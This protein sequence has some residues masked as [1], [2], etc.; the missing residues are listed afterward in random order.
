VRPWLGARGEG[1]DSIKAAALGLDRPRGVLIS[2]VYA[3]GPA[4]KAGLREGDVVLSI[5]GREVFDDKGMKFIAATKA[6]G[7]AV[8]V[9]LLRN[10]AQRTLRATLAAPPG[11]AK[12]ELMVVAGRN[13]FTGAQVAQLSPALAEQLGLDPFNARDGMLVYSVPPRTI[14]RNVGFQ[15]GDIIREIN[16]APIRTPKDLETAI[17][18]I[19]GG[20]DGIWRLAIERNGRR[21][22]VT[23]RG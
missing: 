5:D 4:A 18:R 19:E 11:A 12:A 16:G 21:Q 7:E 3:G 17:N 2:D 1:V 22:E 9:V 8:D 23:L 10:G 14:A 6:E 15:P 20:A 13:P